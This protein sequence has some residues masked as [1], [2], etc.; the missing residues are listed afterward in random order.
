LIQALSKNQD[1]ALVEFTEKIPVNIDII[2]YTWF[3]LFFR[4]LPLIKKKPTIVTIHDVMPLVFSEHYPIGVKGKI[5]SLIQK[6]SLENCK[7]VITDSNQS[8]KDIIKYLKVKPEKIKVVY[9]AASKEYR[10]LDDITLMRAKRKLKLPDNFLLYVGD[11]NYVKNLPLLIQSFADLKKSKDYRYLKLLLIG[12]AFMKRVDN[13]DHPELASIKRVNNLIREL[14]LESEIFRLGFVEIEELAAIY[15]LATIYIQPSF[16]EGFGLPVLEAMSCGVPV[17]C[18]RGGSLEEVSG[19]A[20]LYFD[21]KSVNS[22]SG[23][24]KRLLEDKALRIK[25]IEQGLLNVQSFSWE[26]V[27]S[28]TIEVYKQALEK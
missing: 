22:L 15:N 24:I 13:I 18:A 28:Q 12:E 3:D 27:A 23:A 4:T 8:R 7:F 5:N 10:E 1:I 16:Y 25:L 20:S 26:K 6:R 9:L 11:V 21:P 2:H 14:D 19:N 17:I